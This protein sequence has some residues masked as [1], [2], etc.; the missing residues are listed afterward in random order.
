MLTNAIA[1]KPAVLALDIKP[2]E[3]IIL[4][5]AWNGQVLTIVQAVL[6]AAMT[7]ATITNVLTG[8]VLLMALA[9][10]P[11]ITIAPAPKAMTT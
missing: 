2:A 11:A 1:E 10:I 6:P 4:I 9:T 8:S 5:H 3:I 7:N